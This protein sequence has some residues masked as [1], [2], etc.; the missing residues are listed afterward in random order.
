MT[1][2]PIVDRR[3]TDR[4]GELIG[5]GLCALM[6][7]LFAVVVIFGKQVQAGRLPFVFL[8]IR[9]A[10]QSVLLM[11]LVMATRRPLI[12]AKGERLP[13]AIA[14]TIGYGSESAFYFTAL[15]HG[16]AAAITLLFYTYPVW[17]ML[18]TMALDR[19]A[20]PRG[21]FAA[22]GL[23]LA[24]SAM[25]VLGRRRC[26]HRDDR[27]RAGALHVPGLLRVPHRDRP[28]GEDDRSAHGGHVARHRRR[29]GEPH[30]RR[31]LQRGR[32]AR[33]RGRGGD[34]PAWRCSPRARSPRCWRDCS[35]SARCATPSS[36]SWSR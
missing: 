24:G 19:K 8:A 23:A 1:G 26:R 11:L 25:V 34:S 3:A 5:A 14:G 32:R 22:L 35:G 31:G 12:P 2:A 20:P 17:V 30:V 36:A 33:R 13:L 15:N 21:L 29:R 27:H 16:S 9:F 6:A 10:G 18:A 4:R 28:N 7:V